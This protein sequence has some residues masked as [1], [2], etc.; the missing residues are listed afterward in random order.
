MVT[1]PAAG[2]CLSGPPSPFTRHNRLSVV[3]DPALFEGQR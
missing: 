2:L 3:E 1:Y